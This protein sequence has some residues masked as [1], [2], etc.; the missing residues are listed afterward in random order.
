MEDTVRFGTIVHEIHDNLYT[1][2][3]D[4]IFI[5]DRDA[6][7]RDLSEK[8]DGFLEDF[9]EKYE[10]PFS[11]PDAIEK[12]F[13]K[14]QQV[15]KQYVRAY[16]SDFVGMSFVEAEMEVDVDFHGFRLRGKIDGVYKDKNNALW[17]LETKT[18]G[19]IPDNLLDT[20]ARDFQNQ[21]YLT[22]FE[23]SRG[24][25]V[26][27]VLYNVIRN[28]GI[29]QRQNETLADYQKR[30]Y[31]EIG[32]N[33]P[34]Y[35]KRYE[36]YYTDEDRKIFRAELLDKLAETE[37]YLSGTRYPYNRETAC[38]DCDFLDMCVTGNTGTLVQSELFSELPSAKKE[39]TV[40]ADS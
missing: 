36:L 3:V 11:K 27:G 5:T 2:G 13:T 25:Q 38:K 21:F 18:K 7:I 28:P 35:F 31:Q 17:V 32:A 10:A 1:T 14:A 8:V 33:R 22:L 29:R 4:P 16:P 12:D 26:N 34:H 9:E 39:N 15:L 37:A 40:D 23:L 6:M 24:E 20:M 30:L 19:R